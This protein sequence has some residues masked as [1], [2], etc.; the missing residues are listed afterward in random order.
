MGALIPL[1]IENLPAIIAQA[2]ELF[3]KNS[4]TD[5][6]PTDAE[7]KA[8]LIAAIASSLAVDAAW[9]EQHPPAA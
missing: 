5:P 9:L 2:K 8:A 3:H 4:P 7:I 1:L 6:V